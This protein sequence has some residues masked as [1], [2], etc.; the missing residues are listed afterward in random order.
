V[1]KFA[2][3][4]DKPFVRMLTVII[5]LVSQLTMIPAF[6]KSAETSVD[7]SCLQHV[8]DKNFPGLGKVSLAV[9][10]GG[11][12]LELS[13]GKWGGPMPAGHVLQLHCQDFNQE[14]LDLA[15]VFEVTDPF[16]DQAGQNLYFVSRNSD[17]S[18][19]N[20][21]RTALR[22]GRWQTPERLP[23]PVNSREDEYSPVLRGDRLYFASA[24][25]GGSG[26]LYVV[27]LAAPDQGAILL[28]DTIN[29][30]TG[31]WNL[32]VNETEDLLLYEASERALNISVSGDLYL[33]L[34]DASG[35]WLP[36]RALSEINSAGSELNPRVIAGRLVYATATKGGLAELKSTEL[37]PLLRLTRGLQGK[38]LLVANRSSHGLMVMDLLS[39][40]VTN[41]ISTGKGPHLLSLNPTASRVATV[42]HGVFPKPHVDPVDK[43]PGW[44][45]SGGGRLTVLEDGS[46]N[47]IVFETS[48]D[49]AHGSA[50]SSEAVVWI[51]CEDQGAL[52]SID[53]SQ[54]PPV[55]TLYPT[56]HEVPHVLAVDPLHKQV[57]AV[58]TGSGGVWFQPFDGS[59]GDFLQLGSGSEAIEI[60]PG[61]RFAAVSIGPKAQVAIIDLKNKRS[62]SIIDTGCQFP[63]DFAIDKDAVLWVACLFSHEIVA[64]D[65]SNAK[66]VRRLK[67]THG[68]INIV[69]HDTQFDVGIEPDGLLLLP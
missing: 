64:L 16:F 37:Q 65:W 11:L 1:I 43:N 50:W 13:E 32:W 68:P 45:Q 47:L 25:N 14:K 36:S 41:K 62:V 23:E 15:G 57:L 55:Q 48:C 30:D 67:L 33:S 39:G 54:N 24:R 59:A 31:E 40:S 35:Q 51:S 22:G 12:L 18:D 27:D 52:A 42:S 4:F 2:F 69:A 46:N 34:R 53:L 49:R 63:I 60:L 29:S 3:Q 38:R 8:V 56:G 10:P 20:I 66:V 19:R 7:S 26:N 58:H 44:Q 5:A 9:W 17:G 61:G 6:A 21:W 28:P